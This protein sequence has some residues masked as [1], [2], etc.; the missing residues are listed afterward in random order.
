MK[1]LTKAQWITFIITIVSFAF[2]LVETNSTLFGIGAKGL[3][4][5]GFLKFAWDTYVSFSTENVIEFTDSVNNTQSRLTIES[6]SVTKT[7]KEKLNDFVKS[8]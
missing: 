5:I 8:K 4:V 3:A 6:K 1:K 7:T 2:T